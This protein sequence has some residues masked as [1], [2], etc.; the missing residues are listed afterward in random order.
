MQTIKS[1]ETSCKFPTFESMKHF[2]IQ[3]VISAKPRKIYHSTFWCARRETKKAHARR[4]GEPFSVHL[5][6]RPS[7][8]R[9]PSI[10]STALV[11]ALVFMHRRSGREHAQGPGHFRSEPVSRR[12]FAPGE[13]SGH[14]LGK[15]RGK[16]YSSPFVPGA[17]E[18][19][20]RETEGRRIDPRRL[21]LPSFCLFPR[22]R[23][24]GTSG[25]EAP[26]ERKSLSP[27]ER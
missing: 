6:P 2:T 3:R 9:M 11:F 12:I 22:F 20:P 27:F 14:F 16:I 10:V 24:S 25:V 19:D 5:A 26:G 7:E 23:I 4:R 13:K 18:N 15:K 8:D 1:F 17:R 21:L